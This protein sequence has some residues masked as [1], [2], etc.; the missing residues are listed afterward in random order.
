MKGSLFEVVDG[1]TAVE[2]NFR[3]FVVKHNGI[4]VS[5]IL[6]MKFD[7]LRV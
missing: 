6:P 3:K 7:T 1:G 2:I 4:V 5:C